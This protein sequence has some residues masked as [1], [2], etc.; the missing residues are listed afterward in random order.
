M[1]GVPAHRDP[2]VIRARLEALILGLPWDNSVPGRTD[3]I[4]AIEI[5]ELLAH[6]MARTLLVEGLSNGKKLEAQRRRS[7]L[8]ALNSIASDRITKTVRRKLDGSTI[9]GA[10][11]VRRYL[12]LNYTDAAIAKAAAILKVQACNRGGRETNHQALNV[13]RRCRE[14]YEM[15]TG[16][17]G[18]LSASRV[19]GSDR[20]KN[21]GSFPFVVAVFDVL[22][23]EANAAGCIK[24]V[25]KERRAGTKKCQSLGFPSPHRSASI[26]PGNARFPRVA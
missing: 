23:I 25:E 13:T 16:R 15:A 14:I 7:E 26:L 22:G 17:K 9:P 5:K 10:A 19:R 4:P 6:D 21:V 12:D 8:R 11:L 18:N 20:R 3:A 24:T 1:V 2:A